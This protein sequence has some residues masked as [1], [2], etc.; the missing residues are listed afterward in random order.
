ML[1]L[2]RC[3]GAS[4]WRGNPWCCAA[5]GSPVAGG[6]CLR[7]SAKGATAPCGMDR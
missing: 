6:S 7:H 5:P 4:H 1:D 2:T 3:L